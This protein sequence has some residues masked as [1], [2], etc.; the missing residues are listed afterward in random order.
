MLYYSGLKILLCND[1]NIGQELNHQYVGSDLH[2]YEFLNLNP[3]DII[4]VIS[5][6]KDIPLKI[7]SNKI[8]FKSGFLLNIEKYFSLILNNKINHFIKKILLKACFYQYI[9]FNKWVAAR[10]FLNSILKDK[11]KTSVVGGFIHTEI[12]LVMFY[13]TLDSDKQLILMLIAL[14]KGI[15]Y[16][17]MC[18][19]S[20]FPVDL[21][22]QSEV[23]LHKT[24]RSQNENSLASISE[25]Y[26]AKTILADYCSLPLKRIKIPG[27]WMHGWIPKYHN[28]HFAFIAQH[29][30]ERNKKIHSQQKDPFDKSDMQLVL[31][32]DQEQYL[33]ENGYR[34][35]KAIGHPIIYSNVE[36]VKSVNRIPGSLLVVPPHGNGARHEKDS[37][38]LQYVDYINSIKKDFSQIFLNVTVADYIS[39]D[40]W[41]AFKRIG[42]E[43]IVSVERSDPNALYR[44]ISIFSQFEFLTSNGIGSMLTYGSYLGNKV[45]VAG[46][47]AELPLAL[48]KKAHA[49]RHYPHLLDKQVEL[50]SENS[51]K[52]HYPQLF[53][54]PVKASE[55]REWGQEELGMK[56][57][58]LPCQWSKLFRYD[59]R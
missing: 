18:S 2:R 23:N 40:W 25:I 43:S 11:L 29:K 41:P 59:S 32:S 4:N 10:R 54:D 21:L 56:N 45:S 50:C 53:I 58:I 34:H 24:K 20:Q 16:I 48:L 57:K 52:K 26:G 14:S 37:V 51:F 33:Y 46:P 55:S 44:L 12:S 5:E 1:K 17:R 30:R 47:Y 49:V 9:P 42:I 7:T 31:R 13:D 19:L 39:R 27:F 38:V 35:V 28:T 8:Y 3:N 15:P 36:R 6:S 22:R